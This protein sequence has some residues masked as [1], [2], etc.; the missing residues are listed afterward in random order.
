MLL[1]YPQQR[2]NRKF[3]VQEH[4]LDAQQAG[5]DMIC[6]SIELNL[7]VGTGDPQQRVCRPV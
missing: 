4:E 2:T 7:D 6:L 3:N 5:G 1:R